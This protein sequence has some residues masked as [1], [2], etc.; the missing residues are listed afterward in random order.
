MSLEVSIQELNTNILAL[1][2]VM[3]NGSQAAPTPAKSGPKKAAPAAALVAAASPTSQAA[4]APQPVLA[5][6]EDAKST[7]KPATPEE[8]RALAIK[9]GQVKGRDALVSLLTDFGVSKTPELPP[10]QYASFIA[11]AT[12]K[13]EAPAA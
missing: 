8:V 7:A 5:P 13:I 2:G 12:A 9:L 3:S 4:P 1:I 11:K 10:H 6:K